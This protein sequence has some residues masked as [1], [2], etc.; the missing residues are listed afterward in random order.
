[1]PFIM[2]ENICMIH[3][4]VLHFI[5]ILI[6][7]CNNIRPLSYNLSINKFSLVFVIGYKVKVSFKVIHPSY[8][9]TAKIKLY[10]K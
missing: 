10:G 7:M 2:N 5:E 6:G 9:I 8:I 4:D 3:M 1:M